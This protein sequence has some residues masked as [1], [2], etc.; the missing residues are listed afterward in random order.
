MYC[1]KSVAF[2]KISQ[3]VWR[4]KHTHT[5]THKEGWTVKTNRR[6]DRYAAVNASKVMVDS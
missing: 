1:E 6:T 5:H 3:R 2:D 4:W